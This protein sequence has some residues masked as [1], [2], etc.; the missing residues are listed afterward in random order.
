M[1]ACQLLLTLTLSLSNTLAGMMSGPP[2]EA[3]K[4]EGQEKE[5]PWA[6]TLIESGTYFLHS[7]AFE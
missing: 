6:S 2:K 5:A 7:T 1:T 3:E 4:L